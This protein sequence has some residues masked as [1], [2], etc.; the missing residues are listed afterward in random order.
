MQ[1]NPTPLTAVRFTANVRQIEHKNS[2]E[3][4]ITSHNYL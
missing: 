1:W 2:Y 4:Q 3:M